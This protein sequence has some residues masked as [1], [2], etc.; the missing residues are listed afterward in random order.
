MF[1]VLFLSL[2]PCI[3]ILC[4]M[5]L[6]SMLGLVHGNVIFIVLIYTFRNM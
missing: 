4:V 1:I 6:Q 5:Y 2:L 3:V